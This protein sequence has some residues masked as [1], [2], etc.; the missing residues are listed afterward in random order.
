MNNDDQR[1]Y[2]D[3]CEDQNCEGQNRTRKCHYT[4]PSLPIMA[5]ADAD[6]KVRVG[7]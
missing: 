1:G 5:D 6:G 7:L 4:D 2:N 3:E